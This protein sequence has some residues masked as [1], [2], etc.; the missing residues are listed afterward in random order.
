MPALPPEMPTGAVPVLVDTR[1]DF[2][3]PPAPGE[4][5][6]DGSPASRPGDPATAASDDGAPLFSTDPLG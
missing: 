5:A 2:I 6:I 3:N 4:T 1:P